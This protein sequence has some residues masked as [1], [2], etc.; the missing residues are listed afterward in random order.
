MKK[1]STSLSLFFVL[2]V[3]SCTQ[4]IT[5]VEP[6]KEVEK[7][8][9]IAP[10]GS[11]N[12]FVGN[13]KGKFAEKGINILGLDATASAVLTRSS[14]DT[15]QFLIHIESPLFGLKY[16]LTGKAQTES[17][18]ELPIQTVNGQELLSIGSSIMTTG[19]DSTVCI[20]PL[21]TTVKLIVKFTLKATP[22]AK[23]R[24]TV[25]SGKKQQ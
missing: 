21:D 20:E 18:L 3:F 15:N 12:D 16:N 22:T 2:F 19:I 11:L 14:I 8:T 7:T 17:H 10:K 24:L 5:S 9:V 13:F 4:N 6:Q 25:F 1:Y 23:E